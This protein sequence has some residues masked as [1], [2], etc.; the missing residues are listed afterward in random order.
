MFNV[1]TGL[2]QEKENPI[3]DK[4]VV[5]TTYYTAFSMGT[6]ISTGISMSLSIYRHIYITYFNQI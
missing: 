2:K 6:Y 4:R 5:C 3:R 1:E